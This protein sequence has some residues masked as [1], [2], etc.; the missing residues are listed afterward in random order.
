MQDFQP[1]VLSQTCSR[2]QSAML[3]IHSAPGDWCTLW[4][5]YP[6]WNIHLSSV[7]QILGSCTVVWAAVMFLVLPNSI[8][9][10][11]FI[12]DQEKTYAESRIASAATGITSSSKRDWN[13]KEALE[14]LRDAKTWFFFC[15][16]FLNQVNKN[17]LIMESYWPKEQLPSGGFQAFNNRI[18]EG[19]GF[20]VFESSLA[21]IPVSFDSLIIIL[22]TGWFA[23][24]HQD[25]TTIII[26]GLLVPPT[27]SFML[28]NRFEGRILN[29]LLWYT[30]SFT[31][32]IL[33]LVSSLV[34]SNIRSVTQKMTM[35]ALML[36][37]FCSGNM[38][39]LY[40]H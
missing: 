28:L 15:I 32:G 27:I 22:G 35:T 26:A 16:A 5:N 4:A 24:K 29:L 20:S 37:A 6:A 7:L 36:I 13:A 9:T 2:G 12:T 8:S 30:I 38:Y 14:C 23:T 18:I 33:P 10:A 34:A 1:A 19:F 25:K 40:G 21:S 17:A 3:G 31:H 39:V 11:S